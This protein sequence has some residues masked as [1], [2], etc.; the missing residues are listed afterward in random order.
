L[1]TLTDAH[2]VW[3]GHRIHCEFVGF[4]LQKVADFECAYDTVARCDAIE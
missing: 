3:F 2:V 4:L 1:G